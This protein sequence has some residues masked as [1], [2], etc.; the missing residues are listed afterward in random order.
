MIL[1]NALNSNITNARSNYIADMDPIL[2]TN[3]RNSLSNCCSII[4]AVYSYISIFR[5]S[6]GIIVTVFLSLFLR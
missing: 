6:G 3:H 4:R 2:G 5:R 1:S